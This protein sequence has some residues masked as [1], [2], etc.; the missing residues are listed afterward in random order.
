MR[1]GSGRDE[2]LATN[3]TVP[4][5]RTPFIDIV[6]KGVRLGRKMGAVAP[7]RLDAEHLK[8]QAIEQAGGLDDFGDP[9]FEKPLAKLLEAI[10]GEAKLNAAGDFSA[11]LQFRQVLFH[12]LLSEYWYKR[13]PEILERPMRSPVVIVGPMRSGTTRL[14]RLLASDHRFSHMR[15]FETIS[16]VPRRDFEDVLEGRA[17]DFRPLLAKRIMR[18]ARLANPRTLSIHP[19]GPMEPEE[20]LGLLVA[21]MYGMKH[22]AQ[23]QVPSY[24]RWCESVDATPAYAYLADQLRLIGWSQQVSSIR[25]WILKTPQHMLDLPALL[26][27]FPDARL[28]F[29]HRDPRQVTGSAASLAWNQTIIYSDD[30][31]PGAIGREWLRKTHLQVERMMEA[32]KS[33]P[34]E[35]MIDV[36]YDEMDRDWRG[37]MDRIYRFLDLDIEPSVPAM[38]DYVERAKALKRR[39]HR[40]SLEMFG[41]TPDEVLER[42]RSY[43]EAFDVPMENAFGAGNDRRA[44]RVR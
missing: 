20:E 5:R 32:R 25:P 15:S 19:T 13:H 17:E 2:Y 8:A 36:Q 4:P 12:R 37:T 41:L 16:H 22:E 23:W 29:T 10:E 35:R 38:E 31:E 6:D 33:I 18:V 11:M 40:Y 44:A 3:P 21:S 39:P 24:G 9:W 27:V 26:N 42:M 1:L 14:H 34:A 7:A 28:I 43:I 30:V